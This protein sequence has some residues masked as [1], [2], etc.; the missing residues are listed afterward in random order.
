MSTDKR[1]KKA[2]ATKERRRKGVNSDPKRGTMRLFRMV[3]KKITAQEA[4]LKS[5]REVPGIRR[6]KAP[7][8]TVIHRAK[9]PKGPIKERAISGNQKVA[10]LPNLPKKSL[11]SPLKRSMAK[12]P[13][14]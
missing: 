6:R 13:R 2:I 3:R 7:W 5:H 11:E 14:K 9:T 12:M 10:G 8:A 4:I 1:P